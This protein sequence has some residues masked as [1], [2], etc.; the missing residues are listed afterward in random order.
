MYI[1]NNQIISHEKPPQIHEYVK[2]LEDIKATKYSFVEFIAALECDDFDKLEDTWVEWAKEFVS[3][4]TTI[5]CHD[6]D[7][8]KLP[9]SCYPCTIESLLED[10][11]LYYLNE[12]KFRE[13]L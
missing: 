6:G 4:I 12:D 11:R 5:D 9:I 1:Y 2:H 3:H 10:Y 13:D 7:C 8:V